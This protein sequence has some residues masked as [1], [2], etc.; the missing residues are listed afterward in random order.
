MTRLATA[1][2]LAAATMLRGVAVPA[3]PAQ[4]ARA[5]RRIVCFIPA[6]TQ[7][8]FA[9]GAGSQVVAVGTYDREP[10]A[11]RTLPR[12]GGLLDPDTERILAMR[13]DL[14]VVYD[15][16][17]ELRERLAGAG[18]RMFVYKHG[19]LASVTATMR[20]LGALAGH[21][22]EAEGVAS[23][24][25]TRL[26]AIAARV[27]GRPRPSTMLVIARAPHTL[28]EIYASGGYGFLHDMLEIAGGRDV[29]ADVR[30]ESVQPSLEE[31]LARHPDV[32]VE[33]RY[34]ESIATG[35]DMSPW[36]RLSAVPAVR[37]GRVH[38]LVGDEFVDAG[39][40]IAD[41]TEKLSRVVQEGAWR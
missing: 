9:M 12:V 17:Q 2:A 26:R 3:P 41:A 34:G 10:P 21:A 35:D 28:S 5:P 7:M 4:D 8:L 27:A 14:V 33:L 19:D 30:R 1:L 6:V 20:E 32:I 31:I 23:G 24:I 36:Q 11:V 39:P 29:F 16:Q 38:L 22:R 18:I 25:E 37:N 15:S 40:G 13:P